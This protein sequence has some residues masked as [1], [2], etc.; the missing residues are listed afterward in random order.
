MPLTISTGMPASRRCSTS[1]PP[2]PKMKGSPPFRRTTFSPS[3]AAIS[4]SFSMKAC[5]VL[6]QPPRLPT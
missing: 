2:R 1:S 5:G 4:I 3:R 6:L